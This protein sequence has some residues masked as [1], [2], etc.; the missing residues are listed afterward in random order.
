MRGIADSLNVSVAAAVLLF[1]ARRQRDRHTDAR[2]TDPMDDLRLRDH[3][4]RSRRR[5]RRAQGPRA[6]RLGGHRRSALVRRELPAHRVRPVEVAAQQRRPARREP[7]RPT[8]GPAPRRAA[9]TW[10]IGP[11][12]RPSP[13]TA[14]TSRALEADGADRLP[15]D[16]PDRRDRAGRGDARRRSRTSSAPATSWSRSDRS[17]RCRRSRASSRCRSGRTARPRSPGELPRVAPRPRRRPDGL[18]ARPGLRPLRRADRRSSSPGRASRRPTIRATRRRS[19][20]RSSVTAW[21]SGWASA[22]C[23]PTPASRPGEPHVVDLDDGTSATGHAILLGGRP[24]VPA[25]RPGPRALRR[26]HERADAVPAGRP[27]A[28]RRR[29]LGHRRPGGPRAPH[30]PGPL[31]GRARGPDGARRGDPARLPRPA[32]GDVHGPRGGLGRGDPR[33]GAR[34]RASMRSSSWPTSRRPPRATRS[35]RRSAT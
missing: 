33:R 4:R 32:A 8:T 12:M 20:P 13:T 26:R 24:R 30:A 11:R 18:R 10:S 6:G 1:E 3:R 27:A 22:R 14:A 31:P 19:G 7:G 5:G 15:R 2:Q 21:T 17:R 29:P 16:G 34:P 23:G 35:R 25:R 9:T 28:R